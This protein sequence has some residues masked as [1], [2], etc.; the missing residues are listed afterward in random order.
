M[1]EPKSQAQVACWAGFLSLV[2]TSPII[3]QSNRIPEER[4]NSGVQLILSSSQT[5]YYLGEV[6]RLDLA[7]SSTAPKRY[8][9]NLARYDRSGRMN[10]EEFVVEPKE[11]TQDP[12]QLYFSSIAGFLGGGLTGFEFLTLFPS[13]IHLNLNEWV[14][15]ERPGTY[16]V[17]VVSRRVSDSNAS[18]QPTGEPTEIKSNWIEVSIVPPDPS[19]QQQELTKIRQVLQSGTAPN[20]V[21]SDEVRQA[22]ITQLRY[23]G[24]E[25]AAREL[26]KNLRGE[27]N[28][29]DFECMFGLIGSPRRDAG[30]EEMNR[31]F[32]SPDFPITQMF[33]TTMSILPLNPTEAPQALRTEMEQNRKEL[34]ERLINVLPHKQGKA[35]A[36]TLD[37]V[38]SGLDTKTSAEIPKQLIPELIGTFS[39]LSINQKFD[40]LEYR[41]DA[42]KDARW[43]PTL[44]TTALQYKDYPELRAMDAYQSLQLTGA[45]LTRWYELDSAG[46]REAVMNEIIRPKPRYGANI[47]GLLP[48]KTLPD[49][50]R[51]LAQHFLATSNYEIEGNIASL[52]FRYADSDVLSDVLGKVTENVGKW[53]CDPQSKMLAYILRVDPEAAEP[54]IER[55][56]AARGPQSN[57]CRH[58]IFTEI[59]ALQSDAVLEH[60]AVKSLND[61][62]PEVSNN[63]AVYLGDFGSASAEQPLW[64]RYEV[65]ARGWSGRDKELRFVYGGENPNVWQSALGEDLARA[66]ASGFGWLSD[67][68]KLR[69]I[70]AMAVGPNA[71]QT[72]QNALKA[73][74]ERPVTIRCTP[75]GFSPRPLSCN[76]AQYELHSTKALETKIGQFPHGTK[77]VWSSSEFSSPIDLE[78]TYKEISDF[79]SQNGIQLQRAP[80]APNGIN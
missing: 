20:P 15:F 64:D 48:D 78:K 31:L 16:R 40:W 4:P 59:G 33:I 39:S 42:V 49:A 58:S 34:N 74:L 79:A 8:Q 38:L 80:A 61:Q 54:L 18:S 22:A 45:A 71:T 26:A 13:V 67:E 63:A 30:L 56:I 2:L 70:E 44:Q 28:H 69:R 12:L 52:L 9:I 25:A 32:D 72:V 21:A 17:Y 66:L 62:D 76:V 46:A 53:A 75:T 3:A 41:W 7:F 57:A 6:I 73:W 11:A 47:L 50:Q 5:K 55:A 60:L 37:T 77:F 23:L 10:Y 43:V 65:W 14:R 24:T 19:W 68:S 35:L 29:P 51:Q 27:D 36:V 1:K